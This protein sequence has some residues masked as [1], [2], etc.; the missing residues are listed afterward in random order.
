MKISLEGR[1]AL[2]TGG[3]RGIGKAIAL[4]LAEAGADIAVNYRR[5]ADAA[6]ETVAEI[7]KMG[8]KARAY[9]ASVENTPDIEKMVGQIAADFGSLGIVVNNAGIAS[10][11][12]TVADTDP[13]ELERVLRIHAM[14]PFLLAKFALPHLR[15]EKRSDI[16]VIS[17]DATLTM[18]P[19]GAPYNMGKAASEAFAMT[20]AKEE[21]RNGVRV[22]IVAPGLVDTDLGRRL[23]AARMGSDDIHQ[24]DKRYPYGHVCRPEEVA[25]VVTFLVSSANT[26]VNGEKINVDGGFVYPVSED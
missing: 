17:S 7:E 4:G 10:R 25:N 3:S 5:D 22:N 19:Q 18:F 8:R 9:S 11:G 15:K 6:Q 24:L 13:S 14:A 26:Y 21:M 2:V 12:N 23:V 20:L 16:I 1:V